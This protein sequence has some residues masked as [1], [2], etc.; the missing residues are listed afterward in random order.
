MMKNI[1]FSL[2]S[3][4]F[5][6]CVH[7]N[8]KTE[9][10]CEGEP[11]IFKLKVS[12]ISGKNENFIS[13]QGVKKFES[14]ISLSLN[15][16]PYEA[17]FAELQKPF[18]PLKSRSEAHITVITPPE[19]DEVLSPYLTIDEIELLAKS[20]HLQQS[21]LSPVCIGRAQANLSDIT[22]STYFIVIE[23]TDIITFRRLV[24]KEFVAKGGSAS[25][26]DPEN[27]YPHI[28]IGFSLRDLH[29]SDGVKK[30]KNACISKLDL[31]H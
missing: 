1:L 25:K 15:Y 16:K 7:E 28:T 10:H 23:S 11:L 6:T 27:F 8:H 21:R 9:F 3:F 17:L 13:H 14:Y 30:G 29:E 31:Q 5:F 20:S 18:G 2:I 24:F 26:F 22:Q 19:F 4:L 12:E